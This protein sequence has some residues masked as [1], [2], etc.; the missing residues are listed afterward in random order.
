MVIRL[1]SQRKTNQLEKK[2][3]DLMGKTMVAGKGTTIMHTE[4]IEILTD[5]SSQ[6]ILKTENINHRNNIK[7]MTTDTTIRKDITK[8]VADLP[9][10]GETKIELGK[11][12]DSLFVEEDVQEEEWAKKLSKESTSRMTLNNLLLQEGASEE[13]TDFTEMMM[14]SDPGEVVLMLLKEATGVEDLEELQ[15]VEEVLPDTWMMMKVNTCC[16]LT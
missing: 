6:G 3:T 9:E 4:I 11:E 16:N 12:G 2:M 7:I 8:V 5:N 14:I 15:E 10:E 1:Q 13:E